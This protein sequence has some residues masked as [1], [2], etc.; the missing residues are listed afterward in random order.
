MPWW[1]LGL[2]ESVRAHFSYTRGEVGL[3]DSARDKDKARAV[4]ETY[5]VHL[6]RKRYRD[7][8]GLHPFDS[9]RKGPFALACF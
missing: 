1:D 8:A 4:A 7:T 5:R 9:G 3:A 2:R 6:N